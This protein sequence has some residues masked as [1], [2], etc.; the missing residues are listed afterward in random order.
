[1]P[2]VRHLTAIFSAHKLLARRVARAWAAADDLTLGV[3]RNSSAAGG[4]A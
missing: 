2:P 1:V 3:K 4:H